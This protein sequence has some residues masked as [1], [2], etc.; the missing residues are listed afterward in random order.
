[1]SKVIYLFFLSLLIG[2]AYMLYAVVNKPFYHDGPYVNFL[3]DSSS[4]MVRN[5]VDD[6]V[7]VKQLTDTLPMDKLSGDFEVK[8]EASG[9][10]IVGRRLFEAPPTTYQTSN[11]VMVI[12][13]LQYEEEG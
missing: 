13:D 2:V 5:F 4:V 11:K 12:G 8:N 9:E 10:V 3:E 1:M 7:R 6:G